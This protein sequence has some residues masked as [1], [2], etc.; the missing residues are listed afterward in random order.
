MYGATFRIR[1]AL[2]LSSLWTSY[3]EWT[4]W[5]YGRGKVD[6]S[7]GSWRK[8][9]T[10]RLGLKRATKI[11]HKVPLA[12]PNHPPLPNPQACRED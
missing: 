5:I 10:H 9:A 4:L 7:H 3:L 11:K 2:H 12:S 8:W 6:K 1:Q